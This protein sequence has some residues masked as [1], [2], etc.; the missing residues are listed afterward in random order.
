[1]RVFLMCSHHS[2]K[3]MFSLQPQKFLSTVQSSSPHRC[4]RN[5]LPLE[6]TQARLCSSKWKQGKVLWSPAQPLSWKRSSRKMRNMGNELKR[7]CRLKI[8]TG[9][10]SK[11]QREIKR[12]PLRGHQ[13]ICVYTVWQDEQQQF[14]F[15]GTFEHECDQC[16]E[17]F[18][19]KSKWAT[20]RSKVHSSKKSK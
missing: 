19:T 13:K 8:C 12:S 20:H 2:Q 1:M 10:R 4:C 15:P 18:N 3:P 16:G 14:H 9:T 6:T 11:S 7:A 5:F 17:K